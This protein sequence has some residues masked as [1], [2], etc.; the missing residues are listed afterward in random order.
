ME[1]IH[2]EGPPCHGSRSPYDD[3]DIGNGEDAAGVFGLMRVGE[4]TGDSHAQHREQLTEYCKLDT[5]A[6][7]RLHEA[8]R[9]I[10]GKQQA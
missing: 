9:R 6:M 7:V 4:Y 1:H 8:V 10:R 5:M 2:Q 3:L